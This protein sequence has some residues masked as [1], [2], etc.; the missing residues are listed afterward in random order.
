MQEKAARRCSTKK[1]S[2]KLQKNRRKIPVLQERKTD[3][4]TTTYIKNTAHNFSSYQ[5]A[6]KEYILSYRLDHHIPCK[7]NNNRIHTE[8]EQFN[9]SILKDISY[10]P[11]SD[12]L[13]LKAKLRSTCKK[14][15]KVHVPYK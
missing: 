11:E 14:H 10:I 3:K 6:T 4:S 1:L 2:Q 12:L 8:F 5:L 13:C 9:Q 7:F 15:S